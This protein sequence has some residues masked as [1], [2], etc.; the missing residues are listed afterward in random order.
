MAE[1]HDD[2]AVDVGGHNRGVSTPTSRALD[3]FHRSG[4]AVVLELVNQSGRDGC[5]NATGRPS[6][7]LSVLGSHVA[8][9]SWDNSGSVRARLRQAHGSSW[10]GCQEKAQRSRLD[11]RKVS[12]CAIPREAM[13]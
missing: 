10:R 1:G 11:A 6:C 13:Q 4:I 3:L 12:G 5:G 8:S 9:V 7:L 2:R